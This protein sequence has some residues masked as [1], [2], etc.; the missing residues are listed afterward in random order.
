MKTVTA[1]LTAV[2]LS[3]GANASADDV[4]SPPHLEKRGTVTQL[5][6]DDRPFLIL[7]GELYNSSSSSLD[8]MKPIW[9]RLV[10]MH[11]N[12]VLVPVSWELIEPGEGR[13]DFTLVDGLINGARQHNLRLVFLWF[14]SWKNSMSCY[15]PSWVKTNFQR[16]P[17][18][19]SADG[20]GMDILT[21]FSDVNRDVDARAF[22]AFM[23]HIRNVDGQ[24]HTVIMVQVENEIGMITD[25]R[26]HST[27]ANEAFGKPAPKELMDYL[28]QHRD[29]LI[30]EFRQ[31]WEKTGFKTSGTWKEVF[32]QGP[33]T[34]EIFMAWYFARY[35]SQVAAAGKA[36]YPL[37]MFVNA[38]LI[39]PN[40]KPG[41]YPSAGPLPH[42]MD[43]WRAGAP[44]IDF[45]SPDIYFPNFAEWCEKYH[46]PGNP[47]FIPETRPDAANLFVAIGQ[48]D[49]MG[50]SP[51][52]IDGMS[53]KP[54]TDG[55]AS[56]DKSYE[57]LSQLTPLILEN[58]G[59]GT[60]AGICLDET[61]QTQKVQLG[62]FTLNVAHDYT[63][64]WSGGS[65][66]T[67]S[68]PRFGGLIISVGPDEY[69]IAGKG[70][71]VTFVPNSPGDP[72]AGIVSIEEGTFSN[73]HWVAGRRLNGDESHQGRHLRLPPGQ[74]GIQ[75]V[76]L[77]RYH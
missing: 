58:Q 74:F 30:P 15:A 77:Y 76:K 18:A 31:V 19:E 13:F 63:W 11:L 36:E 65:H 6:V 59:K 5:I 55:A 29:S 46:C 45:L 35:V 56:F 64:A 38:A 33:G 25:A 67:G 69:V 61:N 8:Y 43:I 7:G 1:V 75:R 21:P 14:G 50:Y 53:P 22:A 49:A 40:Y 60:M 4:I 71:I 44:Q 70:I 12:T 73:G 17:R 28:E 54:D 20:K 42:L 66:Q 57:V 72:I 39:R 16:F 48:Y 62:N 32:G 41:Q 34:D 27:A 10:E 3:L 24:K 2:L 23:R 9:P 37:P 47:L 52:G 26:D 68:W 51:F